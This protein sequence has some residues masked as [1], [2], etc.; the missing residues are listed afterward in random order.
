MDKITLS[1]FS[2][3]VGA[4]FAPFLQPHLSSAVMEAAQ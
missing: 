2:G 3:V 4:L 1:L